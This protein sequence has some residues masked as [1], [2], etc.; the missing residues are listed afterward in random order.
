MPTQAETMR[1]YR[2]NGP[3]GFQDVTRETGLSRVVPS[4]GANFGDLDNDGYLDI[5]LGTGAPSYA[6]LM[7]NFMF[8]NREGKQFVDVTSATGTGHL[9]KGH[10][11]ALGDIN[12]DG[13]QDIYINI[14]GFVPGDAYNKAL[15]AN[16]GHG[17]NW[18]AIKL[19]GKKTNR[20]AIGAKIKLT[21]VESG[22]QKSLR[23]REVSS[24][25]SFGS[26]P[27]AQVIGLGKSRRIESIEVRW[28][29]SNTSQR[30][31]NVAVNQFIEIEE[32]A[33]DY[34][35]RDLPSFSLSSKRDLEGG[36]ILNKRQTTKKRR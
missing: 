8:R 32:L 11:I 12:N 16:P 24:G 4:M 17:N 35:R 2:N 26:S 14:G 9:Q 18:I 25:G 36:K 3:N 34:Q 6:A 7:P 5:Y 33:V 22:R 28:P 15:F 13:N 23:Y 10:G 29:V 1:L 30:F 19:R 20:Q 21:L 27:L 31:E